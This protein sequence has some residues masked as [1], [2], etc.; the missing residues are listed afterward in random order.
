MALMSL[1]RR[2]DGYH[3][4]QNELSITNTQHET[5]GHTNCF[6]QWSDCREVIK[7]LFVALRVRLELAHQKDTTTLYHKV[8]AKG[9]VGNKN[10]RSGGWVFNPVDDIFN[11]RCIMHNTKTW[12]LWGFS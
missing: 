10:C 3:E 4:V 6:N 5:K 12:V 9:V 11:F 2:L 1:S 7:A 8:R